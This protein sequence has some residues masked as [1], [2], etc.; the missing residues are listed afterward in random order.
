MKQ[1]TESVISEI[2]DFFVGMK[3]TEFRL[4]IIVIAG[5]LA[6]VIARMI[7]FRIR[8]ASEVVEY[9]STFPAEYHSFFYQ[10]ISMTFYILGF[11]VFPIL[12]VKFVLRQNLSDYGFTVGKLKEH[13]NIYIFM[14]ILITPVTI[15]A[16]MT[17]VFLKAYPKMK[18]PHLEFFLLFEIIYLIQFIGVEFY[19][20]GFLLF[21][22][23]KK[24]G[25]AGIFVQII[26][27]CMIHAAKP[28]PEAIG[29]IITGIVLG[30]YAYKSRSI[31]GGIVLHCYVA[32]GMDV[33]AYLQHNL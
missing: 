33:L 32:V 26:P 16:S 12:I 30:Y 22:F 8:K 29:S 4:I 11:L 5:S 25:T 31:I 15:I 10:S 27:Y 23:C 18:T 28:I 21:E 17:D 9:I 7:N 24:Y 13:I 3:S 1:F 20:R 19:F 2:K 14:F 6:M